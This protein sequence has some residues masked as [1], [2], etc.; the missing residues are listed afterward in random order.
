MRCWRW[1]VS[2]PDPFLVARLRADNRLRRGEAAVFDGVI[3]AMTIWLDTARALVLHQPVPAAALALFDQPLT[4]AAGDPEPDIDNARAATEVW[5]RAIREHV[6]PALNDAFGDAFLDA[7]R[8]ADYSPLPFQLAYLEQVHDRLRIWPEGAFEELRP[9]LLEM[10]SEGMS[11]NQIEERIGRLLDIDAP[12]RRLRA[13]ISAVDRQIDDPYTPRADLPGLYARRYALWEQHDESLGQWQWLARRIAR[14]EIHGAVEGGSLAAAQAVEQAIGAPMFKRWLSTTDTRVRG[15]HAVADGQIVKLSE[16]FTVGRAELQHPGE[17]GGP[18]HE[19][20][21]C[22]CTMLIL[23]QDEVDDALASVWGNL[24]V[25]PGSIRMGP[26]DPDEVDTAVRRWTAEQRGE[27]F[28]EPDEPD[29]VVD[30]TPDPDPDPP[31]PDPLDDED[32]DEDPR[33]DPDDDGIE[34][35]IDD[36]D[37][38]DEDDVEDEDEDEDEDTTELDDEDPD[39]DV[40][41]EVEE[42]DVEWPVL[43]DNVREAIAQVRDSLPQGEEGWRRVTMGREVRPAETRLQRYLYQEQQRLERAQAELDELHRDPRFAPFDRDDADLWSERRRFERRVEELEVKLARARA[44]ASINRWTTLLGP[45]RENLAAWIRYEQ[46][47][48]ARDNSHN[49]VTQMRDNPPTSEYF[50]QVLPPE[51]GSAY[52]TDNQ[53]NLLPPPELE[54]HLDAVMEVGRAVWREVSAAISDDPEWLAAREALHGAEST[55]YTDT[56]APRQRM[57]RAEVAVIQRAL[58][59][60]RPIGGHEQRARLVAA[61]SSGDLSGTAACLEQLRA[62]EQIFPEDWLRAADARGELDLNRNQ[63]AYFLAGIAGHRQDQIAASSRQSSGYKGGF[64]SENHEV[65]AHELGHRMEQ[66]VPGLTY[67]EYALVRRR[68]TVDGQLEQRT[69]MYPGEF[70]LRD[71]WGQ[72]YA[73][74]VYDVLVKDPARAPHEVFQVGIQDVFGRD[75]YRYGDSDLQA[76][77]LAV[78]LT[79]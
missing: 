72:A 53:G 26:D 64:E 13:E 22:R 79:L 8:R 4:A 24:G 16:P 3:A 25:R 21:N 6:E 57:L 5:A 58:A 7:A 49:A 12:S 63:R 20:I 73:G 19:V 47:R 40:D 67:L 59:E 66:A 44:Q 37:D 9:E 39:D 43:S 35:I 42:D 46:A 30:D 38:P 23:E 29:A 71:K 70:A 74:K 33:P 27:S 32:D 14:T 10:L 31:A 11:I 62:A 45:A 50:S 2:Q 15:S 51:I 48:V 77:V 68:A 75:L 65:M 56:V 28:D 60:V 1:L 55:P 52:V 36:E 69:E 78:M 54:Q 76:F 17:A 61:R 34:I 41:E 18:A